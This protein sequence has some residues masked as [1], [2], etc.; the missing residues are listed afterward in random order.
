MSYRWQV[1]VEIGE[2][3]PDTTRCGI[4]IQVR[5]SD[6]HFEQ[7]IT[8]W[9]F[10]NPLVLLPN[11][12]LGFPFFWQ[13]IYY[14]VIRMI[15]IMGFLRWLANI[16]LLPWQ[17]GGIVNYAE[18]LYNIPSCRWSRHQTVWDP[19]DSPWIEQPKDVCPLRQGIQI[20]IQSVWVAVVPYCWYSPGSR[21][22]PQYISVQGI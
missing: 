18:F 5:L 10:S 19:H 9:F 17:D 22:M 11:C 20:L 4:C 6:Q 12:H 8:G 13:R 21:L 1:V 16:G 15:R 3:A 14:T 7:E 2:L